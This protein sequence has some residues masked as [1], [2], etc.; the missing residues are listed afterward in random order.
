[1]KNIDVNYRG[2]IRTL[3]VTFGFYNNDT[4]AI[5]LVDK[6]QGPFAI[7]TV[8]LET[9]PPPGTVWIKT[10]SENSEIYQELVKEGHLVP[11]ETKM[12]CGGFGAMAVACIPQ[13]PLAKS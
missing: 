7:L 4:L 5:E 1:M 10:W 9:L 8:N 13:G 11:T 3:F 6:D 12:E 2:K